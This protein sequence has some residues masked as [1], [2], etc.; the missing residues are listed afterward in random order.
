MVVI[1]DYR[2]LT[3]VNTIRLDEAGLAA[4][5]ALGTVSNIVKLGAFHGRDDAFY[6][7]RYGADLWAPPGMT[8]SRG[9]KTDQMLTDGKAGPNP[10]ATAFVFDTPKLPEAILH[11]KRHHGV[12][13]ACDSFQN[14]SG[15]DEY[16]NAAATEAKARLGFFKKAVIGPGWRKF[17]EPK[18]GDIERVLKLEFRHLLSA[19]GEPLLD[20]AYSAVSTTLGELPIRS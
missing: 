19:H 9:E 14:M 7:D 5:D 10:D 17:A 3:L 8:Y 15:P 18:T 12:L 11:L 20:E 1:R 13:I 16:F 2:L 4:L 6:I